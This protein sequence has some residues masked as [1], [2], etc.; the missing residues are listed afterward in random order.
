MFLCVLPPWLD[1]LQSREE[2][3][4]LRS[5]LAAAR[6]DATARE[7]ALTMRAGELE[8]A[9]GRTEAL[10]LQLKRC[11]EALASSDADRTRLK[12]LL[13]KLEGGKVSQRPQL[14][15]A[16]AAELHEQESIQAWE[17]VQL[18]SMKVGRLF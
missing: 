1:W 16:M 11:E 12:R 8:M 15:M 14:P 7:D 9:R 10:A 4:E 5:A 13:S 3:D 2:V 18:G 17:Q 6:A